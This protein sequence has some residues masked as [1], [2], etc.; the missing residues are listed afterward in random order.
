MD[1]APTSTSLSYPRRSRGSTASLQ[2]SISQYTQVGPPNDPG[3]TYQQTPG[4]SHANPASGQQHLYPSTHPEQM[5]L[6]LDDGHHRAPNPNGTVTTATCNNTSVVDPVMQMNYYHDLFHGPKADSFY[7]LQGSESQSNPVMSHVSADI[8]AQQPVPELHHHHTHPNSPFPSGPPSAAFC[9]TTQTPDPSFG[10]P[11]ERP[12]GRPARR[13]R[14]SSTSIAND[15]EL[16]RLLREYDGYN[17]H[18]MASE[19]Q[20][21]DGAGGKSEK[22]KQVFAMIW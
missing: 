21:Y 10:D 15:S 1:S 20:K 13:E 4:I 6:R 17:L 8:H 12:N 7:L 22:I 3:T 2:S 5:I 9:S 16:K 19:V 14:V 18:Q 11:E